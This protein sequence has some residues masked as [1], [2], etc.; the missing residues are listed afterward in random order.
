MV[1]L[2]SVRACQDDHAVKF[3]FRLNAGILPYWV[4]LPIDLGTVQ[5]ARLLR[6][7]TLCSLLSD[8]WLQAKFHVPVPRRSWYS[9][10]HPRSI[11]FVAIIVLT[12][13]RAFLV[14]P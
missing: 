4:S 2:L 5:G 10:L 6:C 3:T 14:Q 9:L 11:D 7:E 1:G 12:G 13:Y 8:L